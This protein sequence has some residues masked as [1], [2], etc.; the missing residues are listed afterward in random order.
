MVFRLDLMRNSRSRWCCA[1]SGPAN[2]EW[3]KKRSLLQQWNPGRKVETAEPV[4]QVDTNMRICRIAILTCGC[5]ALSSGLVQQWKVRQ[6][7]CEVNPA[8]D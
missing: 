5:L 4:D 1:A 7:K 3:G 8:G 6:R 2:Q